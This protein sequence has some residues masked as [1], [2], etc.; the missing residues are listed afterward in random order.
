MLEWVKKLLFVRLIIVPNML[1]YL[2]TIEASNFFILSTSVHTV[3]FLF[4][5]LYKINDLYFLYF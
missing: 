4:P 2:L 3:D 1:K 5:V